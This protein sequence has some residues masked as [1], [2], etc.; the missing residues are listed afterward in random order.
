MR[1][2]FCNRYLTSRDIAHGIKY[3]ALDGAS[4]LFLPARDSAWTIVCGDC[5]SMIYRFIYAKLK[6]AA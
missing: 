3:G 2:E 1:C 5:G 6:Q 4:G